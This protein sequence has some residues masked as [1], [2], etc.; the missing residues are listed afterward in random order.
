MIL[1]NWSVVTRDPFQAPELSQCLQGAVYGHPRFEDG[2]PITTSRIM[3]IVDEGEY[4]AVTTRSGSVYRL[5]KEDVD[6]EAERQF[7]G[8]YERLKIKEADHE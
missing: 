3:K 5:Y 4:K 6:S 8:Y 1:K 7:P 2:S